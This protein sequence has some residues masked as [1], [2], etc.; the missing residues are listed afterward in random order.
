MLANMKKARGRAAEERSKNAPRVN[1]FERARR[2]KSE[3]TEKTEA[4]YSSVREWYWK[5]VRAYEDHVSS[6]GVPA[7]VE[8][9]STACGLFQMHR[10][11]GGM[12]V[13][14]VGTR[15][16]KSPANLQTLCHVANMAKGSQKG[17]K[18][19]YRSDEW[20]AWLLKARDRDFV[21]NNLHQK[22]EARDNG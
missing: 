4:F 5:Q 1:P 22:W 20:K 11:G 19:D 9:G 3:Q 12:E 13:D 2:K 16:D 14:H 17:S 21:W 7:L 8:S 10:C 18:Y 15:S 6:L